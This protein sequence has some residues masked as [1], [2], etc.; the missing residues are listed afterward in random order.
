MYRPPLETIAEFTRRSGF[1]R[2]SVM[3]ALD[4]LDIEPQPIRPVQPRKR[5]RRHTS[6]WT[7]RGLD[8]VTAARVMA[9]LLSYQAPD[10]RFKPRAA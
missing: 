10:T 3:A 5:P 2:G 7:R 6:K 1:D 9:H 4:R 8:A